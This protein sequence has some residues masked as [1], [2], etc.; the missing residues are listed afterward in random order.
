MSLVQEM[1]GQVEACAVATDLHTAAAG[2][3]AALTPYGL[4]GMETG[5]HRLPEGP[6]TSEA[7]WQARRAGTGAAIWPKNWAGTPGYY[8]VCL[9]QNP[10][11][12]AV[13]RRLSYYRFSDLA[14]RA[15]HGTYWEAFSEGRIGD[16][17]GM[18]AFGANRRISALSIVF[19]QIDMSP[20][21]MAAVRMAGAVLMERTAVLA[22]PGDAVP[23]FTQRERDCLAY[24]AMGKSD[25]DI[26]VIL[27]VSRTT[28]RF[29]V[30]NARRKLNA[31][32]RTQAVA[33]M[34]ALGLL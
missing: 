21:E 9:A 29:H 32:T 15:S 34:A 7:H 19:E 17:I 22:A 10:L 33:R 23:E 5:S 30:D 24:V 3:A 2:F 27:G 31:T 4:V 13:T 8:Y 1:I 26:S 16:G 6:L 11:L 28:V 14:P 20:G 12:E 25:W 18:R